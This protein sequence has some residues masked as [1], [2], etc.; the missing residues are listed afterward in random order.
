MIS[1][2]FIIQ[3]FVPPEI[4]KVWGEKSI[5]FIDQR[6]IS[7]ADFV[8]EFFGASVTINNWN[9]GGQFH[10]SG[11]RPP[12]CAT[13]GKLSQHKFKS[14]IDIKVAGYTP[15]QIYKTILANEKEFMAAGLTTMENI[16]ATPTWNHLDNRHTGL[17][18]ILIVNP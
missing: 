4:Y 16:K 2:Y 17:K 18:K 5:W 1:K 14:A 9:V 10:Y 8:H 13:G 6:I 7:L 11:Y 15:Q 3:E 12:D